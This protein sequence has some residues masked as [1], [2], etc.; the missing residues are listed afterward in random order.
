MALSPDEQ[1]RQEVLKALLR[2]GGLNRGVKGQNKKL[3]RL[4]AKELIAKYGTEGAR[5]GL[6]GL[7][8]RELNAVTGSFIGQIY[9]YISRYDVVPGA[10]TVRGKKLRSDIH[11]SLRAYRD[12]IIVTASAANSRVLATVRLAHQTGLDKIG[13]ITGVKFQANI[14]AGFDAG[15]FARMAIA[16]PVVNP[17][18]VLVGN[19]FEGTSLAV[20]KWIGNHEGPACSEGCSGDVRTDDRHRHGEV[21]GGEDHWSAEAK[22]YGEV[23]NVSAL[24]RNGCT[25]KVEAFT[26]MLNV[27]LLQRCRR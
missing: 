12:S 3:V 23:S 24:S 2:V 27:F 26:K 9:G 8:G 1:Y 6:L 5:L 14:F 4:A 13:V 18:N 11:K 22:R 10:T 16:R 25:F 19:A 7:S 21:A 20:D 17:I 15:V